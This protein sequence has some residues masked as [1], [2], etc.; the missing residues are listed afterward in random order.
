MHEKIKKRSNYGLKKT[1]KHFLRGHRNQED[2]RPCCRV[3]PVPTTDSASCQLAK[4]KILG[5]S[6]NAFLKDK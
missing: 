3:S 4:K 1:K 2:S 5:S 6:N